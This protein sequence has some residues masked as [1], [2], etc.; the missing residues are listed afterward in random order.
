MLGVSVFT[1]EQIDNYVADVK[2]AALD[3]VAW[4]HNAHLLIGAA[5]LERYESLDAALDALRPAIINLNSANNVPNTG[6]SGYHETITRF[7]LHAIEALIITLPQSYTLT[8]NVNAVVLSR[9]SD[10]KFAH[11]FYSHALLQS[12]ISRRVWKAPNLRPMDELAKFMTNGA[13]V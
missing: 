3:R 5:Y 4:T 6:V 9:L 8:E 12:Y 13:G 1:Q 10:S 2:N 7:F 11:Y